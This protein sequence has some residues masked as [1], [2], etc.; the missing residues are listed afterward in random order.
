MNGIAHGILAGL[1]GSMGL[2]EFIPA[3]RAHAPLA[4]GQMGDNT[5][6]GAVNEGICTDH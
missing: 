3:L 6:A 4:A 2:V 1:Q 5:V